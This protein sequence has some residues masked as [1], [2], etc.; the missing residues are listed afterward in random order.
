MPY[1][2]TQKRN[3]VFISYSHADSKWLIRLQV[4]LKPLERE[5]ET[6]I[7]DDTKIK[8]GSLWK[9]EIDAALNQARVAILLVSADFIASDF[10]QN[11]E[12]PSLLEKSKED[13]AVIIPVLLSPSRFARTNLSDFQA[14]NTPDNPISAMSQ[15]D[16]EKTFDKV[17]EMIEGIFETKKATI[18]SEYA[19]KISATKSTGFL[20]EREIIEVVNASGFL[21]ENESVEK[22]LLIYSTEIQQTWLVSTRNRMFC[23]LNEK[24]TC[25]DRQSISWNA[26]KDSLKPI[27]THKYKKYT[28]L[29]DLKNHAG[30]LYTY[31]LFPQPEDILSKVHALLE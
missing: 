23:L 20:H 21:A 28:G 27:S 9:K 11:Y 31:R 8:T 25:K 5:F 10:I 6:D 1:I 12:L 4:H 2:N 7:W 30:W 15:N 29:L 22:A 19:T 26:S 16:Q 13:G 24:G 18:H 3:K 14:V 17:A